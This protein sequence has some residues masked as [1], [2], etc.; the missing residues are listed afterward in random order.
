MTLAYVS[1]LSVRLVLRLNAAL[2]SAYLGQCTITTTPNS[3]TYCVL[4]YMYRLI[5]SLKIE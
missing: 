5:G 1:P 2:A 4:N 3:Y